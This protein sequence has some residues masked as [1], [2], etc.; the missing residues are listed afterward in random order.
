MLFRSAPL[1]RRRKPWRRRNPGR[2]NP[3]HLPGAAFYDGSGPTLHVPACSRKQAHLRRFA[4]L[5]LVCLPNLAL[6]LFSF[7]SR[8]KKGKLGLGALAPE[9]RQR[10][11][12]ERVRHEKGGRRRCTVSL[13]VNARMLH[14][15]LPAP[16][17]V[18]LGT[19]MKSAAYQVTQSG[20]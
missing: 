17:M 18:V 3:L 6:F 16:R 2:G 1:A 5:A 8:E 10:R 7:F 20:L 19:N 14:S 12:A 13:H 4:T 15:N 11:R 9:C